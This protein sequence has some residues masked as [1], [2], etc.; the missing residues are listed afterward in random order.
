LGD[1]CNWDEQREEEVRNR[2]WVEKDGGREEDDL[3]GQIFQDGGRTGQDRIG[4]DLDE[5]R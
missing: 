5:V 3:G 4:R 2:E 1:A